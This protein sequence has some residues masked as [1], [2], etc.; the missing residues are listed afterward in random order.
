[1]MVALFAEFAWFVNQNDA[2]VNWEI[3]LDKSQAARVHAAQH[4][5]SL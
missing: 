5:D 2:F 1:M 4:G 3:V